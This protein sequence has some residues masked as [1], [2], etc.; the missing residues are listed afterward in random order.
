[1]KFNPH[2]EIFKG[3]LSDLK[4]A[5][6][7]EYYFNKPFTDHRFDFAILDKKIAFEIDGGLFP[8]KKSCRKNG[9]LITYTTSGGHTT[10]IG[11]CNDRMKDWIADELGWKVK[12]IPTNWLDHNRQKKPQKH[13][14]TYEELKERIK[15]F[16]NMI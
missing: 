2:A 7:E 16:K 3:L 5:H 4:I 12:R 9:R 1:M 13:L 11:Y 8:M 14:M 15:N 10:G 6:V